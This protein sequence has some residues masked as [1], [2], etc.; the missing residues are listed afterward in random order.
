MKLA[1][2]DYQL[3]YRSGYYA[4]DQ[5]SAE[6]AAAKP[7]P[8][9]L[10]RFL[11]PGL[12]ESTQIPFT[13]RV[14]SAQAPSKAA[15]ASTGSKQPAGNPGQGGDNPNLSGALTRYA[16]DFMIPV[17]GLQFETAQD[18]HRRVSLEVA[19]VVY[20]SKGEALNWMLETDRSEPGYH[21]IR[22]RA[23]HRRK[24]LSGD[25]FP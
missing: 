9:P 19:L 20:N 11:Q 16:V 10:S 22:G 7:A 21:P 6:A 12:P 5:K 1:K 2:P 25:R 18:G 17:R 4:D 24:F 3:A 13:V 14:V 23:G 15:V 8:D